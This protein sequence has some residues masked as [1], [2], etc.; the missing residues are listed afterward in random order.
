MRPSTALVTT[1][2]T[3]GALKTISTFACRANSLSVSGARPSPILRYRSSNALHATNKEI[4]T[5]AQ[6]P[7][8]RLA[9]FTELIQLIELKVG[10]PVG[11]AKRHLTH[12]VDCDPATRSPYCHAI[13]QPCRT[14]SPL[15]ERIPRHYRTRK[16][17]SAE[18]T[19]PIRLPERSELG[20]FD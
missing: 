17:Y 11:K 1:P 16:R 19:R 13:P 14:A 8:K 15:S 9:A 7:M 3:L 4:E 20:F 6:S 10:V 2:F 12:P 5:N 18:A